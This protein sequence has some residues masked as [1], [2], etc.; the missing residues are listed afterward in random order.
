MTPE[1]A[2]DEMFGIIQTVA[3]ARTVAMTY[4]DVPGKVPIANSPWGRLLLRHATGGQAS[5]TGGLGTVKF[6]AAGLL[7]LQ[8][9]FPKGDGLTKA[10]QESQYFLNAVRKHRGSVWFR[11][12]RV[13]ERGDDGGFERVDVLAEFQY[14]DVQ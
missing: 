1:E 7:W 11:N 6:E 9:F 2:R 13:M 3:T 8:L 14:T 4:P 12:M 10:Y 5:L